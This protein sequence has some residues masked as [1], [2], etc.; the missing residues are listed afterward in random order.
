MGKK[1]A[2]SKGFRKYKKETTGF[3]TS[4]KRIMIF[5]LIGF[6]V[7]LT[8]VIVIPNWI[9]NIGVL[10][11]V[12]GKVQGVEEDWLIG[13][14]GSTNDPKYRKLAEVAPA[15]G[16]A[17][18]RVE[19]GTSSTEERVFYYKPTTDDAPAEEYFVQAG[20][21]DYDQI[22]ASASSMLS[23]YAQEVLF[24]DEEQHAKVGDTDVRY[25]LAEY[26]INNSEDPENPD[27][28][29]WQSAYLYMDSSVAGGCVALGASNTGDDETAFKDRDA[30][31]QLLLDAAGA[32][33][34][35]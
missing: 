1:S 26:V 13:N 32:I 9:E 35:E 27:L 12:D 17:L 19:D 6:I 30:L 23:S 2:R 14:Y 31:Y 20:K 16:Y 34:A 4:E 5:G 8:C 29:Y 10:K 3:T 28:E 33:Q 7:V 25:Y 15:E 22:I 24:V 21:N 11:M 18:D